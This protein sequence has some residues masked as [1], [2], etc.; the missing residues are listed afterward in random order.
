MGVPVVTL[1]GETWVGRLGESILSAIGLP[2]LV[3]ETPEEYVEIAVRLA[4]DVSRLRALRSEL[5]PRVEASAFC[6][7]TRFTRDLEHAFRGMWQKWCAGR[8][9]GNRQ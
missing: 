2:E 9:D 6:D 8:S 4:A 7:G 1:R 3:A 5:R